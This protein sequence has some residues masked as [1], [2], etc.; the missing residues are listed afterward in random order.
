MPSL[1]VQNFNI[2]CSVLGGFIAV[3]GLI[4]FL[5]K[6][7]FY[8]SE[9]LISLL[10]GVLFGPAAK[11]IRP[12]EYALSDE[13]NLE[14][15]NLY[16][17]RLV[18]GVQLVIAGIQLPPK[19][20]QK[21]WKSLAYLIGPGMAVMWLIT[22]MLIWAMVPHVSFLQA[23]AVG[24]CVTPTDPILSN[25]I[26]KGKFADKHIPRPLQR[27]VIAESGL[28]DGL[29]YPFL[30][31]PLY[32][33]TYIGPGAH[34]HTAGKAMGLWFY[35]TWCYQILLSCVYGFACGWIAKELLHWAE[36]R[37]Y[38]DRES[39]LVFALAL[40]IFV[41]GTDGL[42]GSDDVLACFV[43]GNAFTWDDWFRQET[44]DD[45]LQPTI[46]M[47]LNA[48]I[49]MWFGAVCPWHKFVYNEVIP[50]YRLIPLGILVILF[51]RPPIIALM[52]TRI[53]QIE[54]WRQAAVVG[55]FGPIGV[56]AIFYLY[57]SQEYLRTSVL[58]DNGNQREDAARLA[59]IM[60]VVI[61][62]LV[63][64]SVVVH[65]L[66]IPLVK[67][68][69]KLPRT[70]S[71]A[72]SQSGDENRGKAGPPFQVPNNT[73]QTRSILNQG[74]NVKVPATTVPLP[75]FRIGGRL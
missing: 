62:F 24:A 13:V 38:V 44:A 37:K 5:A 61:W 51:R 25:S 20:L 30:F 67:L 22:S 6:D 34:G 28:N 75:I 27:I 46:D 50:I 73:E 15:I 39:F 69:I 41:V 14:Y 35:E 36:N 16:F 60:M 19:Y 8:L 65:G 11:W 7:R 52:H 32:L 54:Q 33:I 43:A 58:D 68:G 18:L 26:L 57:I 47:L 72:V 40:A 9:A 71:E 74:E 17:C 59:E 4:S 63:I 56:S 49:F 12:E 70:L 31:L 42:L 29:G 21:E 23:L 10:A 2:V 3:F 55:F 64:C 45:T 1:G 66:T 53:H 48:A